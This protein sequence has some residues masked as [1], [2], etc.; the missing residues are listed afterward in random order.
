SVSPSV[1]SI[2]SSIFEEAFRTEFGRGFNTLSQ[3]YGFPG[4]ELELQ[5]LEKQHEVLRT[6]ISPPGCISE[7]LDYDPNTEK[8]TALDLGCVI[9]TWTIE[10][11]R[12]YPHIAVVGVDLVPIHSYGTIP[13]NCRFEVDDINLGLDHFYGDFD[14]WLICSGIKNYPLLIDQTS[15]I[16]RGGLLD[17]MEFELCVYDHSL[18]GNHKRLELS[19]PEITQ[20]FLGRWLALVAAA[21]RNSGGETDAAKN[22]HRWIASHPAFDDLIHQEKPPLPFFEKF[23]PISN[24]RG[25]S[26]I[27]AKC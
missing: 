6:I 20:P 9:G 21:V 16:L 17:V 26:V 3:V 13:G 10:L 23:L 25:M 14:V 1:F 18:D 12:A 27:V 11:A 8:K 15:R 4:D 5:R 19:G 24:N 7:I 2:T 22:L